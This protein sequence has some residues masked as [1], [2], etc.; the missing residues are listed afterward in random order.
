[1]TK[2]DSDEEFAED[3]SG[4]SEIMEE[5]EE[6]GSEQEAEEDDVDDAGLTQAERRDANVRALLAN[7]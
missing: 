3:S 7:E 2:N 6:G 5:A 1:M 4:A